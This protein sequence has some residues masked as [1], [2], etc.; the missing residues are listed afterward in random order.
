MAKMDDEIKR[1][2][3]SNATPSELE[4]FED[5]E[6]SEGDKLALQSTV[7]DRYNQ[8]QVE[9]ASPEDVAAQR[10][11][12]SLFLLKEMIDILSKNEL[13]RV[14]KAIIE[15][16]FGKDEPSF[17]NDTEFEAFKLGVQIE[18][19]KTLLSIIALGGNI[20]YDHNEENGGS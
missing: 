13:M 18:K 17:Q 7:L 9:N 8:K 4:I 10:L 5:S 11:E 20:V 1:I 12:A 2:I 15:F 3:E 6:I 16:P 14:S 19:D